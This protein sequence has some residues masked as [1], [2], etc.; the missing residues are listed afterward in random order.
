MRLELL[1]VMSSISWGG[2]EMNIIKIAYGMHKRGHDVMIMCNPEGRLYKEA[3][4]NF[5][6]LKFKGDFANTLVSVYKFLKQRNINVVHVY[7]SGDLKKVVFPI[8][9]G[10]R[11]PVLI[12]DPQIG[13]GISRRDL[14]H[15]LIYS[16]VDLV[17]AVSRDVA[18][19]YLRNLPVDESKI[20]I[21][22]PGVDVD[23]F[24]FT[25]EGRNRIRSEFGLSDEIIIGTVSRFSPGKGHEELFKAFK[26][27]VSEFKNIKLLIVGEP[28][29]GETKYYESLKELNKKLGIENFTVWTGFRRDIPEVLSAID[30]FVAPSHAESFGLYL[31]EAMSVGLPVVAT[32]SAGFLDIVEDGTNGLF[33][34]RGDYV[35]LAEKIKRL[36]LDKALAQ[37]LGENARKTARIR[38]SFDRYIDEIESLYFELLK[39]KQME[40]RYVQYSEA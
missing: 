31:V 6:V 25:A 22:Y 27:L 19:G 3:S 1:F 9:L 40:A 29:V 30:I 26:I 17:I 2:L 4:G 35:D 10:K 38:F 20:K 12:L 7:K 36:M 39:S 33:F 13:I 11:K 21:V 8:L 15:K 14:F 23:K 18:S 5:E 32:K 24:Q 34:E 16:N 37:T 28:T